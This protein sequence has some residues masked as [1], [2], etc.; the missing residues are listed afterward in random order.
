MSN[1]KK[2]ELSITIIKLVYIA[3]KNTAEGARKY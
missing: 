3:W 2:I 1:D